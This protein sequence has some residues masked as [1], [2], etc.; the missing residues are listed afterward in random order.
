MC[1]MG[2][3]GESA[4]AAGTKV[5]ATINGRALPPPW[6]A[7]PYGTPR[8]PA[9]HHEGEP[10]LVAIPCRIRLT[11]SGEQPPAVS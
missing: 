7:T 6:S 3:G 9:E 5:P 4:G 11:A 10:L 8:R 2:V 1:D